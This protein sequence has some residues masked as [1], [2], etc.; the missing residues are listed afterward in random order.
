MKTLEFTQERRVTMNITITIT[1][2][3]KFR[4]LCKEWIE[5]GCSIDLWD[6]EDSHFEDV[7]TVEFDETDYV[8]DYEDFYE[9]MEQNN[10]PVNEEEL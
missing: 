1:D 6:L 5:D 4:D 2:E 3:E 9:L 8:E 7:V 10:Y